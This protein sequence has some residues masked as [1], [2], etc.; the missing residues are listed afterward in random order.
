MCLSGLM[1]TSLFGSATQIVKGKISA[2]FL[3][4]VRVGVFN[5]LTLFYNLA[6][7]LSSLGF[8]NGVT[9]NIAAAVWTCPVFVPPQ[10]LVWATFRSKATG[11][12]Q[13]GAECL[14]RGL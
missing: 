14:R 9:R 2:V 8:F 5:Q 11:L 10:V 3:G 7:T 13:P 6:M 12:F 1:S 4:I